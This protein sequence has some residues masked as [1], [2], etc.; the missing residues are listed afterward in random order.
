[1][2]RTTF[3]IVAATLGLL[4]NL[5]GIAS[6]QP[7]AHAYMDDN[8]ELVDVDVEALAS[9]LP[10][11]EPLEDGFE[12]V[13]L[14]SAVL[15]S[16]HVAQ[17]V[18]KDGVTN[19]GTGPLVGTNYIR[20]W[21]SSAHVNADSETDYILA[22]FG[23]HSGNDDG[24]VLYGFRLYGMRF[25]SDYR[26]PAGYR[27]T[28]DLSGWQSFLESMPQDKWDEIS[29][30]TP[31]GDGMLLYRVQIVH[32]GQEIL[33]WS[34]NRWLDSPNHTTLGCAAKIAER[35]L[36]HVG[37]TDH[38][39]IYTGALEIGKTNG[40]KYGTG[41]LWCSEFA[42]WALFRE[43]FATPYGNIGTVDMKAWFADRHRLYTRSQVKAK[44]YVPQQGDYLSINNGNHSCL[45]LD[46]VDPTDTITDSTRFRTLD[47]NWGQTVQ[48]V[49]RT[50]S[51]IDRVGKA[52]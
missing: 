19:D 36:A 45:F 43:G 32:S 2:N 4:L 50:V 9:S 12:P 34:L 23:H 38:A 46:W 21:I 51:C 28:W 6:A 14:E 20:I 29:L 5:A 52:Q 16:D 44:T 48:I 25:G 49:T 15:E 35:K 39:A 17:A 41:N 37:A 42:S 3:T 11:I 24:S 26:F 1:M 8:V 13:A 33:D 22:R 31:S 30:V 47:G 7:P 40:K 18:P 27:L 10:A